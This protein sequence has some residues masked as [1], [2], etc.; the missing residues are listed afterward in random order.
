[1]SVKSM[2]LCL[3]DLCNL[4]LDIASNNQI[5]IV[6][7]EKDKRAKSCSSSKGMPGSC[8]AT[9]MSVVYCYPLYFELTLSVITAL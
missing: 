7:P 2:P 8:I 5:S 1:M 4:C 3:T 9:R 6:K